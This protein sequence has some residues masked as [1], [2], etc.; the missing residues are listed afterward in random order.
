MKVNP[1]KRLP[2]PDKAWIPAI[3]PSFKATLSSPYPNFKE[4]SMKDYNPWTGR[5]S[6]SKFYSKILFYAFLINNLLINPFY[7]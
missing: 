6:W 1:K 4:A 3:L 7:I 5:Y 2:V